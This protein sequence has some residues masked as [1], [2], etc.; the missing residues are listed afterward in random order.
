MW[1]C[2]VTL[3]RDGLELCFLCSCYAWH[4]LNINADPSF[5]DRMVTGDAVLT[6]HDV[7]AL[8]CA[9]R[10][11]S[12]L[13]CGFFTYNDVRRQCVFCSTCGNMSLVPMSGYQLFTLTTGQRAVLLLFLL[14]L[15]MPPKKQL[16][17]HFNGRC[18][19]LSAF[20]SCVLLIDPTLFT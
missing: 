18:V 7:T 17:F 12:T 13:L 6:Y 15:S 8:T 11:A 14:Q 16:I 1:N 10:C 3:D 4:G 19:S 20:F 5:A 9:Q 2:S